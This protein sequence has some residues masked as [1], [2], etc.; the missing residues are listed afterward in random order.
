MLIVRVPLAGAV[1]G[2]PA[3][4]LVIGDGA[5][6]AA[7]DDRLKALALKAGFRVDYFDSLPKRGSG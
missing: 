2:K 3:L 5:A 6:H 1:L 4:S 7:T